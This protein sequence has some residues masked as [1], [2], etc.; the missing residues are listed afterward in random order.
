MCGYAGTGKSTLIGI[1][2]KYLKS[3]YIKPKYSAPTHRANA[4]TRMNNP[5]ADVSTL[6]SLFGLTNVIDLTDGN[7]DLRKLKNQQRNRPKL[8]D[9]SVLIIDEASMISK[10]LF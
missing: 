5:E 8:K 2:D 7:Y 6:H 3:K 1:F 4:V 9:G 10:G